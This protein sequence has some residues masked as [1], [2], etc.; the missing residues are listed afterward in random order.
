MSIERS[1]LGNEDP[2]NED[3]SGQEPARRLADRLEEI[4]DRCAALAVLRDRTA[5]VVL[6]HDGRGMPR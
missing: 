2:G 3:R 4:A 5:D 1:P 6:G